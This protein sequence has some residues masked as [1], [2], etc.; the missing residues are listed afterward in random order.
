[1]TH[2]NGLD[3]VTE[4]EQQNF[5]LIFMDIQMPQMDGVTACHKIKNIKRNA[6][7]P[8]IAVTAHAMS[9][10]RDR[11]LSAGMDDYLTKPIEEHVLQH[12]LIKWSPSSVVG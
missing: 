10:E 5:D 11:L 6:S 2:T 7:T 1:M 9:G 12:V 8:V 3:A 4:A